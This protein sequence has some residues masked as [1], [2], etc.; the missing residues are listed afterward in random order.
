M[1]KDQP[2]GCDAAGV[3]PSVD[4]GTPGKANAGSAAPADPELPDTALPATPKL[5]AGWLELLE[6]LLLEPLEPLLLLLLPPPLPPPSL[7]LLPLLLPLLLL[8]PP[9]SDQPNAEPVLLM[10]SLFSASWVAPALGED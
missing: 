5:K 7:L 10:V 8:P 3:L 1:P 2:A 6:P 9:P 4:A